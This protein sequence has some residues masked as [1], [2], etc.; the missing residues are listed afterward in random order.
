M[1]EFAFVALDELGSEQEGTVDATSA[2]EAQKIIRDSGYTPVSVNGRKLNGSAKKSR[3]K[4]AA[5]PD[6]PDDVDVSKKKSKKSKSAKPKKAKKATGSKKV[7]AG[8][9][10]TFTRQL[11]TLIDAG[12]PL[13]RGLEVLQKQEKN[14]GLKIALTDMVDS[15]KSGSNFADSLSSHPKIFDGLYIN[16]V[17]AGEVGGVLDKVL[18]SLAMFLEKIQKIKGKVKSALVYPAVV[19]G[20]ALLILMFLAIVIIPKFE[21]IFK[22]VLG[23]DAELPIITQLVMGVSNFMKNPVKMGLLVVVLVGGYFGLQQWGKT[24]KG[25]FVLDTLKLK[26]PMFGSLV[27]KGGISRMTRTLGTLMDAGVAVLQALQIVRDTAGN[28]VLSK[29]INSVHD[30]VKEGENMAAPIDATGIFPPMV[31]SMIEVGEE[32]GELPQMLHRIADNYEEEVD[33]AV[34]ALTSIIEPIMIVALAFIVGTI[35]IALFLPLI[36]LVTSLQT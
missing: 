13:V 30:S 23:D 36:K 26:S 35:V 17:K 9:L 1:P 4:K 33:N 34:G 16:M 22:D 8:E 27:L 14:L 12:L 3:S 25:A 2:A 11:A 18:A 21:E 32:T 28:A 6:I 15:I 10:A 29:A 19:M 7:K 24:P 5:V 31:V 20:M